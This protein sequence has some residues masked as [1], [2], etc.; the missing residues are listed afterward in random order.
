MFIL[1]GKE[2]IIV[3]A[4]DFLFHGTILTVDCILI[5]IPSMYKSIVMDD[6]L[7]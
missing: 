6:A 5:T 2:A 3:I 4:G 7:V 1:D